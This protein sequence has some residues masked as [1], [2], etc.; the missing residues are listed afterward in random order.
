[1]AR[2]KSIASL[3]RILDDNPI[4]ADHMGRQFKLSQDSLISR[5][6]SN[7]RILASL[8]DIYN[9]AKKNYKPVIDDIKCDIESSKIVTSTL[10]DY[11]KK[12]P[13]AKITHYY[14]SSIIVPI[15]TKVLVPIYQ[16]AELSE[17]LSNEDG[18]MYIKAMFNTQDSPED[19]MAT[20]RNLS[21]T[22][23]MWV[24]TSNRQFDDGDTK[25]AAALGHMY[26]RLV[27][28]ANLNTKTEEGRSRGVRIIS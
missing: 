5:F 4:S 25:M 9:E 26:G 16:N 14:N 18:L 7:N 19:I 12:G 8:P 22:D 21:Y 3:D 15:E 24:M 17:V 1:M 27:I 6:N 11:K 28:Y 2:R 23:S 10:I 20:L 13:D